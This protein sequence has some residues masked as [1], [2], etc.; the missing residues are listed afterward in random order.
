[1][2]LS[3]ELLTC[4]VQLGGET[5]LPPTQASPQFIGSVGPTHK[6]S[7]LHFVY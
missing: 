5:A 4:T 2:L 3:A 7:Q 1:M 6:A